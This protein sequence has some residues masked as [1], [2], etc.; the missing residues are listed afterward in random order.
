MDGTGAATMLNGLHTTVRRRMPTTKTVA[1]TAR[2]R[3]TS[4]SSKIPT[5]PASRLTAPR[6]NSSASSQHRRDGNWWLAHA[7]T[8]R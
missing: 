7:I 4:T 6:W 2:R 8:S 1:E 3:G 5:R